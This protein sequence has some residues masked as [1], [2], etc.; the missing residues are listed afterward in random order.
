MTENL[1]DLEELLSSVGNAEA[2]M[3]METWEVSAVQRKAGMGLKI[4]QQRIH[5]RIRLQ[6]L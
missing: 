2:W 4:A 5:R 1:H 3:W 6:T